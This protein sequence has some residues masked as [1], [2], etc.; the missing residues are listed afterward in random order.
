MLHKSSSYSLDAISSGMLG[1]RDSVV[2]VK[3]DVEGYELRV[4]TGAIKTIRAHMPLIEVE[5]NP[6]TTSRKDAEKILTSLYAL[7]YVTFSEGKFNFDE[8]KNVFFVN[9]KDTNLVSII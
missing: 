2:F 5:F 3:I 4:I 8:P 1:E 7:G 9:D 6:M